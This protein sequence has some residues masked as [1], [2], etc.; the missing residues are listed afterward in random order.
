MSYRAFPSKIGMVR[1]QAAGEVG[2][3]PAGSAISSALTGSVT[4]RLWA[5]V[6][7]TASGFFSIGGVIAIEV[8]DPDA[9]AIC[10]VR[11]SLPFV[12]E[13]E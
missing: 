1:L 4:P 11:D 2:S 12:P 9:I 13:T 10:T 6:T 3:A 8:A 7:G 5:S